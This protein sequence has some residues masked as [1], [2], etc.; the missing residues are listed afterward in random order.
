TTNKSILPKLLTDEMRESFRRSQEFLDLEVAA[1][2]EENMGKEKIVSVEEFEKL[3]SEGWQY[4]AT[5]PNEKIL[6]K[7]SHG[8]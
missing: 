8:S 6:V 4:V 2:K 1:K 5:L 7:N 3:I